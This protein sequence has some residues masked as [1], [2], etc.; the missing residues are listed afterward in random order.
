MKDIQKLITKLSKLTEALR[1]PRQ[2]DPWILQQD[3]HSLAQL[4]I[5]EAY[6]FAESVAEHNYAAMC[7]ELGDL[8]LHLFLYAQLAKELGQFE[9]ADI[10][11]ST[12]DKQTR[13]RI[14]FKNPSQMSAAEALKQWDQKKQEEKLEANPS[15]GLLSGITKKLPSMMRALKLQTQAATVGFDWK[16]VEPIY[17]KIHEELAEFQVAVPI[18]DKNHLEEELGD[19]LFAVINLARHYQINPE[20]ALQ[21]T[22][23]KFIHRFEQ[24]EKLLNHQGKQMKDCDL[25]ELD[26][27][28]DEVKKTN[29]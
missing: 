20:N 4:T 11:N 2:G 3:F 15:T 5:E 14:N 24:M 17:D 12:L 28:W 13:R 22:N 16:T 8:I 10:F 25:V 21:R 7:D 6:E 29:Y 1:D 26:A 9:L 23:R 19:L 27:V 18:N